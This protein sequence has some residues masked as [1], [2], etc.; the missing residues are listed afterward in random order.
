MTS[1]GVAISGAVA[2]GPVGLIALGAETDDKG[3]TWDCWKKVLHDSSS[4]P[5]SGKKLM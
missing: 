3:L 5:S 1:G 4:S 2:L